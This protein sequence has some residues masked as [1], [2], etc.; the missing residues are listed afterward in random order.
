[1]FWPNYGIGIDYQYHHSSGS[2]MGDF[3]AGDGYTQ[4]YGKFTDNV[5]SSY[6]GALNK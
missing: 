6:V 4:I 3:D 5:F 1:M 2:M